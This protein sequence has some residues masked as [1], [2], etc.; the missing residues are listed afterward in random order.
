MPKANASHT[1][2]ELWVWSGDGLI[3]TRAQRTF[4]PFWPANSLVC[5]QTLEGHRLRDV[6]GKRST[7]Q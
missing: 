7:F 6:V 1:Y 4:R 3:P 2:S 5:L